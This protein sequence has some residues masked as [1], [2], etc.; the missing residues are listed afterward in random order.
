MVV[1][2]A[3]TVHTHVI[4]IA[5]AFAGTAVFLFLAP[6]G[7]AHERMAREKEKL[8]SELDDEFQ[9]MYEGLQG[10][11]GEITLDNARKIEALERLHRITS[12]M[13]EWPARMAP[14]ENPTTRIQR[15]LGLSAGCTR[16]V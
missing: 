2:S 10:N 6:L 12:Q 13:R 4:P 9:S 11:V 1:G 5:V 14:I 3:H 7:P 16:E 8:L 15:R